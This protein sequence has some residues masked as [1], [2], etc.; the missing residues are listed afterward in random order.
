MEEEER[1]CMGKRKGEEK[2]RT[3]ERERVRRR[4]ERAATTSGRVYLGPMTRGCQHCQALRLPSE[5]LNCCH[6]FTGSNATTSRT[7]SGNTTVTSP[8]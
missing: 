5:P 7:T 8:F 2:E 1:N 6:L 4:R 3:N